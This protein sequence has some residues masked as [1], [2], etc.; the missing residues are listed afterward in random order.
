VELKVSV[1]PVVL[2]EGDYRVMVSGFAASGE[3]EELND[4]YVFHAVVR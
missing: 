4:Y 1:P 2:K 3:L